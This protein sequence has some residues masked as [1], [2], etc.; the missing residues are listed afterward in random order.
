[1]PDNSANA[2]G[3]GQTGLGQSVASKIF[4]EAYAWI[5]NN[6]SSQIGS[7]YCIEM[8]PHLLTNCPAVSRFFQGAGITTGEGINNLNRFFAFHGTTL[9]CARGIS[10]DGWQ[11]S[12]RRNN[13]PTYGE[14][15]GLTCN[16]SHSYAKGSGR[17]VVALVVRNG[18]LTE[19]RSSN[20]CIVLNP[21]IDAGPCYCLP[22]AV[23][24]YGCSSGMSW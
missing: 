9:D 23:V 19:E 12:R 14:Y 1:M 7:I 4:N 13:D 17:L 18:C 22:I 10:R 24:S 20:Y 16:V 11:P 15:F 2:S 3:Q 6:W 5:T 21:K 8:N